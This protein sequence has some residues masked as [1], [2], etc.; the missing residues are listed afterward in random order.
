MNERINSYNI[1]VIKLLCEFLKELAFLSFDRLPAGPVTAPVHLLTYSFNVFDGIE[2]HR[3]HRARG[4]FILRHVFLV[5]VGVT[6]VVIFI[7]LDS[8]SK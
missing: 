4:G 5:G 7:P 2:F 6:V 3:S 8:T 1:S